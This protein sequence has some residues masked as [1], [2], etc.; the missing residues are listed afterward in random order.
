MIRLFQYSPA[1]VTSW[2][3]QYMVVGEYF[4]ASNPPMVLSRTGWFPVTEW[5]AR[6]ACRRGSAAAGTWAANPL[7]IRRSRPTVPPRRRTSALASS[8]P[9][10]VCRTTTG[11]PSA[12]AAVAGPAGTVSSRVANRTTAASTAP[13]PQRLRSST[14]IGSLLDAP[15]AAAHCDCFHGWW[16]VGRAE[17][18]D[19]ESYRDAAT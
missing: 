5:T 19:Q 11:V 14:T 16:I 13:Q 18:P 12:G 1:P 9:A 7:M 10:T 6:L 15:R 3:T 17:S 4:L 2:A 8:P